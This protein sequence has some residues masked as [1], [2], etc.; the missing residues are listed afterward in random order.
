MPV[1][2]CGCNPLVDSQMSKK[3]TNRLRVQTA[4]MAFFI[5]ANE[6]LDPNC[7]RRSRFDTEVP[8]TDHVAYLISKLLRWHL[9]YFTLE[10]RILY[11]LDIYSVVRLLRVIDIVL[12]QSR[13]GEFEWTKSI[14]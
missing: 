12:S 2:S 1:L 9:M 8:E 14:T 13:L 7:D 6:P 4:R 11:Q 3:L 10:E 5:E